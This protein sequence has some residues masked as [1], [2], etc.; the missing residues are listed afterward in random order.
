MTAIAENR[1]YVDLQVNG[2]MGVDFNADDLTADALHLACEHLRQDG[3]AAILATIITDNVDLM[4][5][6]IAR[7]VQ[8]RAGDPLAQELIAGIH[9]EGPFI[10]PADGYRGA[11]PR[12]GVLPADPD[13]AKRLLDAGAGLVRLVTLAPEQDDGHRLVKLLTSRG[14]LVSAGHTNC[15]L[16]QLRGA[17]DSGLSLFTHL[18]NG[19]PM[20]MHRHDNIIQRALSLSDRLHITFIAD[21]VH[22][23]FFALHNYI[24]AAGGP[25]RCIIVTDAMSAAGLGP[26]QYR[27]GRWEVSIGED[28][29][30]WAPDHSHLVGS[31]GTMSRSDANLQ[32]ALGLDERDRYLLLRQNPAKLLG[33][34]S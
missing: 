4:C 19:C 23:P 5:Q 24:R 33:L 12:D 18:G 28:L 29:A 1:G 25:A 20:Q 9:V 7:L 26:G 21:G 10:S 22:I 16:D 15:S 27:L 31:A 14:V 6:R 17:I 32:R 13:I 8:L 30:A 11:H 3:V 2:Y 34:R